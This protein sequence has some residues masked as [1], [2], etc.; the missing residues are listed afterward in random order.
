MDKNTYTSMKSLAS[1]KGISL[2]IVKLAKQQHC[3][4]FSLNGR[5]DAIQISKYI[6]EH[7]S[8]LEKKPNDSIEYWKKEKIKQDVTKVRLEIE[9]LKEN[10]LD[11]EEIKKFLNSIALAQNALFVG[12]MREFPVRLSGKSPQ[13]I[14]PII[15]SLIQEICNILSKGMEEWTPE[16]KP[17]STYLAKPKPFTVDC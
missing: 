11:P 4:G 5:M 2:A 3:P 1:D 10:Y 13:E 14:S 15:E 9:K 8:E 17:N 6:H 7:M 16:P 12:R